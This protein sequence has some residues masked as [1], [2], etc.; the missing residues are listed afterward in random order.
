MRIVVNIDFSDLADFLDDPNPLSRVGNFDALIRLAEAN[1]LI[2]NILLN[3][4]I[5]RT[6]RIDHSGEILI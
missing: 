6:F 5:V 2:V 4:Q 3:D 1:E